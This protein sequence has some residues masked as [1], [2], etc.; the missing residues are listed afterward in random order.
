MFLKVVGAIVVALIFG[1]GTIKA[2]QIL[3]NRK[4]QKEE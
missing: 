2:V 3:S 1:L 4:N